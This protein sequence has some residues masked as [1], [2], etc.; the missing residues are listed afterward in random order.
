M[1][2][3]FKFNGETARK[4]VQQNEKPWDIIEEMLYV[5]WELT[6]LERN[7]QR[8]AVR[9]NFALF[10]Y[11]GIIHDVFAFQENNTITVYVAAE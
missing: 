9:E 11:C 2:V 6:P 8:K 3:I 5:L 4:P 10:D 1:E 7:W